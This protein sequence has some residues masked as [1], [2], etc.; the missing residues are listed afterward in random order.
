L[1]Y[2]GFSIPDVICLHAFQ[3]GMLGVRAW[4]AQPIWLPAH[5]SNGHIKRMVLALTRDYFPD[6][7]GSPS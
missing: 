2:R 5:W 3:G 1:R 7:K 4:P 6:L